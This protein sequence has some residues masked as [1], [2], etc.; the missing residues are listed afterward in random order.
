MKEIMSVFFK[1]AEMNN[2]RDA[3][4]HVDSQVKTKRLIVNPRGNEDS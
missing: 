2:S 1:W 4:G 3:R